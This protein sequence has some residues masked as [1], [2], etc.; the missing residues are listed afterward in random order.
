MH[1][2]THTLTVMKVSNHQERFGA[3]CLAQPHFSMWTRRAGIQTAKHAINRKPIL[4]PEQQPPQ[5]VAAMFTKA[6]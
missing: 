5:D 3:R 1:T 2:H 4:P 6:I